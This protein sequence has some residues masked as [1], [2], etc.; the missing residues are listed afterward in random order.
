[1]KFVSVVCMTGKDNIANLF[2]ENYSGLYSFAYTLLKDEAAAHDAVHDVFADLL[3]SDMNV[4][5]GNGYL[6][7]C[8]RNKCLNIIRDMPIKESVEKLVMTQ[9]GFESFYGDDLDYEENIAKI[10]RIICES[11]P[12]Q[13]SKVIRL[14]YESGLSYSDIA[15]EL[16][17]S[18]VAVYKH[19]KN[20]L[21]QIRAK[22]LRKN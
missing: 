22:L 18:K 6:M 10:R 17:I 3:H 5:F 9:S 4:N 16:G 8:V 7:R 19:L 1:M 20:G 11:L 21:D 12:N 15:E 2:K 13:C 14:R